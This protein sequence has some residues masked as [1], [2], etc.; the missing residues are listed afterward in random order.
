MGTQNIKDIIKEEYKRCVTD[1]VHFMSKYCFVQHPIRGK[2]PFVLYPFQAETLQELIHNRYNIILKSRQLG[3]STLTAAYALWMMMF[4]SDKNILVIATKQD[5]AKNLVTKVR[6]MHQ[7]LPSWLKNSCVEDNKLSLR[8]HNGSQIKAVSSSPDAGRSE[9]LSLL[10]IDE[11]AFIEYI[12]DIWG[13]AQQTLATGGDAILLSTPNGVGN[14]FHKMWVE[15]ERGENEFHPT[16]LHWSVHPERDQAWRDQ[17]TKNLGERLA[18]Q[19]CDADFISSGNTVIVPDILKFYMDTYQCEPVEK[20]GI[21]SG[22][23]VWEY[24]DYTRTYAVSADVA[25]G[26]GNDYSSFHV[27]DVETLA[28][29]AE[30]KGKISTTDFG[31]LCVN[32]A[33]EYNNALLV[34]ENSGLG[35]AT[36]QVAVDRMYPNLFYSNKGLSVVDTYVSL[37]KKRLDLKDKSQLIVGFSTTQK[38]RP[39]IISKLEMYMNGKEVLIRSKRL[40]S[41]LYTFIWKNG[42]AEAMTGYNDDTVMS[43]GIGLWVRDTAIRLKKDGIELQKLAI[44]SIA[45]VAPIMTPDSQRRHDTW[46]M[47]VT[48]GETEDLTQWL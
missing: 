13:A 42:K 33:T 4:N 14:F 20:R 46:K 16:R 5:V 19:E 10:I 18:A 36:A 27:I 31:N 11:A 26:D 39:L 9:A 34:I 43:Y 28:Q 45:R 47:P 35:W 48:R 41:E 6:V 25:R 38:T 1:P 37:G 44:N 40:L 22:Y 23:W 7:N 3:I 15:S 2:I 24:P 30:Y 12:D 8:F 17:Q 32:V 29:V 21:D